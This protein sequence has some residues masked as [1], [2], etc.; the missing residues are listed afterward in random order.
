VRLDWDV[1]HEGVHLLLRIFILV[2]L[3]RQSDAHTARQ[4]AHTF[5]PDMFVQLLVDSYIG[6]SHAFCG[7]RLNRL[8]GMRSALFELFSVHNFVQVNSS[9]LR[10]RLE[11]LLNHLVG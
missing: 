3:A 6:R 5:A 11:L 8:D 10:A 7:N 9:V 1:L 2:A 4:I